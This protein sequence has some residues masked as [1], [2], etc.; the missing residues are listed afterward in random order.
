[1][2]EYVSVTEA[3]VLAGVSERTVRGWVKRGRLRAARRGQALM[4]ATSELA[5]LR[6]R[7][8]GQSDGPVSPIGDTSATEAGHLAALVREL[9]A[10]LANAT[11]TIG[12]WQGRAEMLA[13]QLEDARAQ[14]ALSAPAGAPK[15]HEDARETASPAGAARESTPAPSGPWWRRALAAL[16]GAPG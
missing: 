3:A 4:I 11:A 2:S 15:S 13:L 7:D 9:Q 12:L 5:D 10:D 1:M 6:G 16:L 14:L 8:G